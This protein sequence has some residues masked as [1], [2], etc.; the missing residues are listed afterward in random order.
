V[1]HVWRREKQNHVRQKGQ[2]HRAQ[3]FLGRRGWFVERRIRPELLEVLNE[4]SN[5]NILLFTDSIEDLSFLSTLNTSIFVF[6]PEIPP[7]E[8]IICLSKCEVLVLSKSTFSFW[9]AGI[10]DSNKIIT[11]ASPEAPYFPLG[12]HVNYVPI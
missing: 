6:G 10:S 7:L 5:R 8:S 11:P 4:F 9:A 12:S 3:Y 2:R 1:S